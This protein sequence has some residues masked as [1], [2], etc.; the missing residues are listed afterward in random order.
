MV[1]LR[2]TNADT[3]AGPNPVTYDGSNGADVSKFLFVYD[4]I[5]MRGKSDK[6]KAAA[7]L[8]HVEGAAFDYYYD[9]YSHSGSLTE[10]A[11]NWDGVKSA[12]PDCFTKSPRPEANIQKAMSC[13]LDGE[14][15]LASM[16][17]MKK[18]YRRAGFN[19]EAK[20]GL[21]RN[22]VMEPLDVAQVA[23]YRS[24]TTYEELRKTVKDFSAGRDAF[25]EAK[26]AAASVEPVTPKRVL[27]RSD[28]DPRQDKLENKVDA[29]TNQLAE[30]SLMMKKT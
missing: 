3:S 22:A 23:I 24:P 30:L 1:L 5:I 28:V 11:S 7:I 4:N 29:I 15:L 13:R 14:N 21:L 16:D 17:E 2:R 25:K 27:L 26:T 8:C 20:Y 9:T 19:N 10:A 12:L 6:E 18:L